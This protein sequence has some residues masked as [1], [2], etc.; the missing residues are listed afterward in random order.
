MI[1]AILSDIH[2]NLPSLEI[3]I[4]E[5]R[6]RKKVDAYFFL[7]DV[8]N[9]GP[10]SNECVEYIQNMENTFN[11]LGNHEE[12]FLKKE[13]FSKHHL[14]K[15]F[16]EFCIQNFNKEKLIKEYKKEIIIDNIK[17]IHTLENKYIF[18]DTE[19]N[20]KEHTIIGH[21]HVQFKN[22]INNYWL[23]NPGSV[24]QNRK[25]LKVIQYGIINTKNLEV[26]FYSRN[27]DVKIVLN[28]MIA[29]KYPRECM[30]YYLKKIYE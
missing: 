21:S 7:G 13:C 1:A 30:E 4:K 3:T 24:G 10:W 25:N 11:I 20:L 6:E 28:E 9:Y 16:F 15:K 18:S 23:I 22:N 17:L 14:A 26:D 19:V 5:I 27:Y 8:V 2:G 12:Y 29:K